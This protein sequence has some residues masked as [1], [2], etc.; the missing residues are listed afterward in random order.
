MLIMRNGSLRNKDISKY[1]VKSKDFTGKIRK[2][3]CNAS[4]AFVGY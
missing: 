3:T 2:Q 4:I 1:A